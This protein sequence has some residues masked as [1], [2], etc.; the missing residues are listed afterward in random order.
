MIIFIFKSNDLTRTNKIY[1]KVTHFDF[2]TQDE[3]NGLCYTEEK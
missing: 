2:Y 3:F 1:L